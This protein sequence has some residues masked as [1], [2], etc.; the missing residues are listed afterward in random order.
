M[1]HARHH[2][3][4]HEERLEHNGGERL[5]RSRSR[6]VNTAAGGATVAGASDAS[7]AARMVGTKAPRWWLRALLQVAA[8]GAL[9]AGVAAYQTRNHV[10]QVAPDFT[11]M[12]LRGN[13]VQLRDYRSK[14]VLLHFWATWCGVCKAE[15]PSLRGLARNLTPDEA[16]VTVVEDSD[17]I[18]AVRR[19]AEAHDLRYPILLGERTVLRA[20]G[21]GAFPTN[22]YLNGDG[23]IDSTSVGI[24]TRLGMALRLWLATA[25]P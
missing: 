22:Y 18:E 14:K 1:F 20:Y 15:L 12:D 25:A 5:S 19:F 4:L 21:V 24:S 9:F 17:D 6:Q 2:A 23:A 3:P 13:R 7:Y 11:L 8:V 10:T 16:L